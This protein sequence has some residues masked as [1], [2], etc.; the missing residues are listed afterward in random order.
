MPLANLDL[1]IETKTTQRIKLDKI[2]LIRVQRIPK[3][4]LLYLD[5][6]SLSTSSLINSLFLNRYRR[7]S[8]EF[9]EFS[10]ES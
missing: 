9:V 1:K 2:G 10:R 7:V 5:F 4:D 3:N 6:N 8:R